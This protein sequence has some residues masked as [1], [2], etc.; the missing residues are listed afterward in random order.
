VFIENANA[1]LP[2]RGYFRY[3]GFNKID[4][5]NKMDSIDRIESFSGWVIPFFTKT[6]YFRSGT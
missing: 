6:I 1:R 2:I 4:C 3:N 5:I